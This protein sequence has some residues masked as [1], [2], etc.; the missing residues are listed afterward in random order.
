MIIFKIKINLFILLVL[1][2]IALSLFLCENYAIA[3]H[4]PVNAIQRVFLIK[5]QDSIGS[6]FTIDIDNKQYLITAKHVVG[7]IKTVDK[8]EILRNNKWAEFNVKTISCRN[9]DVDIIVLV[10]PSQI[11][12]SFKLEPTLDDIILSQDVFFL[13]FPFQI[14]SSTMIVLNNF[15]PFPFIKKGILSAIDLRDKASKILYI[16]GNNNPGFSGGPIIFYD[17]DNKKWKV[18]GVVSGYKIQLNEV[19]K[20]ELLAKANSGILIG[21]AIDSAVEAIRE[22]PIGPDSR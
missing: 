11:S 6:S 16:D 8:I 14:Y 5:Y 1:I 10:L 18:A 20:T 19:I 22:N 12:P 3:Q 9:P 4:V 21:Y 2:F 7:G 13:G 15:Y 17:S